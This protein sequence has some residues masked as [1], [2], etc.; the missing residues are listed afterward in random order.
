M[1]FYNQIVLDILDFDC[2]CSKIT[3]LMGIHPKVAK[4]KGDVIKNELKARR[5]IWLLYSKADE[6]D[7]DFEDHVAYFL[8]LLTPK[9]KII[10]EIK[11][12]AKVNVT[13]L[14]FGGINYFPHLFFS[15][16]LIDFLFKTGLE[17]EFDLGYETPD[18]DKLDDDDYVSA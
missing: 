15:K 3:E 2:D 10:L 4:N 14:T 7:S 5:S 16:E 13:V 6:F 18:D 9:I 17:V 8:N 12:F 11:K 1:D